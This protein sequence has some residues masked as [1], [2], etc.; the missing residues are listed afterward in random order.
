MKFGTTL[1]NC[2]DL[3]ECA[4]ELD[5]QITGVKWV[6]VINFILI[7]MIFV[8]LIIDLRLHLHN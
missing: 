1:K 7:L 6:F 4:K 5:V 2:R 8:F 3:L